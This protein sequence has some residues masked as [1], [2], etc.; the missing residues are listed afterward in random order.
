MRCKFRMWQFIC[1][2]HTSACISERARKERSSIDVQDVT[3][4]NHS[5][6][7]EL[8]R[9]RT[10]KASCSRRCLTSGDRCRAA[11]PL[12]TP[13]M[14]FGDGGGDAMEAMSLLPPCICQRHDK[15]RTYANR[16]FARLARDVI[17]P[18]PEPK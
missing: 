6:N 14:G 1:R 7:H 5:A 16:S 10:C 4:H 2:L 12:S 18:S 8:S 3:Q 15:Q 9:M 17:R 11:A 13:V